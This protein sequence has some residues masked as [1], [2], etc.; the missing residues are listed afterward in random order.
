M[1]HNHITYGIKQLFGEEKVEK[2]DYDF[3]NRNKSSQNYYS[4]YNILNI[5]LHGLDISSIH[6]SWAIGYELEAISHEQNYGT[7]KSNKCQP[8]Q[9]G[10]NLPWNIS[11]CWGYLVFVSCSP[12]WSR[13]NIIK[14]CLLRLKVRIWSLY[15][16]V[17]KVLRS[18]VWKRSCWTTCKG[19]HRRKS[20]EREDK[21][22]NFFDHW[23]TIKKNKNLIFEHLF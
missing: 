7:S 20:K 1:Q 10:L 6:H 21:E 5:S 8:L 4:Y 3:D 15:N 12:S 13:R 19:L 14:L 2:S 16:T 11:Q 9:I 22:E 23:I 17:E 18:I